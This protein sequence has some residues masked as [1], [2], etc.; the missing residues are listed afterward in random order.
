MVVYLLGSGG[1]GEAPF[2]RTFFNTKLGEILERDPRVQHR[3][4]LFLVDGSTFDVCSIDDLEDAYMVVRAFNSGDETC[5]TT[6]HLIPYGAVYRM[7]ISPSKGDQSE[8][9][10]FQWPRRKKG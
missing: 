8:R 4:R 7:E 2:S 5:S 1:A 6:R 10:G 9:V 3:V